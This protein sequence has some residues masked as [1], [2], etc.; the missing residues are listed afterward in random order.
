MLSK[1]RFCRAIKY[2][3][4]WYVDAVRRLEAE[5]TSRS[6]EHVLFSMGGR[7]AWPISAEVKKV[8]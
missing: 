8:D 4:V 5:I 1:L 7:L 3:S 6:L 2:R